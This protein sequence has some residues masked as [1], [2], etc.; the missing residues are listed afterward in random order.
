MGKRG[1]QPQPAELK[2]LRGNP[3]KRAIPNTAS[4]V[5]MLKKCPASLKGIKATWDHYGKVLADMGIL[6]DSDGI[7]WELL[8]RTWADYLSACKDPDFSVSEK[9]KI[10]NTVQRLLD[11]FGMSPSAR[12]SIA[13]DPP[14]KESEFEKYL[15]RNKIA[16]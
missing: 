11:H 13:V 3:G 15:D 1:P 7:S 12:G 8:W 5:P 14:K 16:T 6:Q 4:S 10:A 2:A 9:I